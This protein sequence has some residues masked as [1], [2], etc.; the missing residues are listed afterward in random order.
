MWRIALVGYTNAGKSTLMRAITGADVFVEDQLFATL[1]AT[2]RAF[3]LAQNKQVVMTD[4]VGFIRKLPHD[5]VASFRSTLSEANE[6]EIVLHVVDASHP[7]AA[8]H[9]SV[10]REVL[11]ELDIE[12]PHTILVMNKMDRVDDENIAAV[13][14]DGEPYVALSSTTGAGIDRLREELT[15]CIEVDM[16][17]MEL[18]VPQSNGK[19]ISEIHEKGEVLERTYVANDV[20]LRTRLRRED[21]GVIAGH[22]G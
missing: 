21:A 15:A 13:L 8:E 19:L 7:N 20:I 18:R 1:D 17:E 2:T 14:S 10:V 22:V 16:V 4:T 11:E 12:P 9:I 5:L 6:A 3:D